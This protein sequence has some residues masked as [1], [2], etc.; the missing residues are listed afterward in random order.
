MSMNKN[1]EYAKQDWM[2]MI[3]KSGA[4]GELTLEE[5]KDFGNLIAY[6]AHPSGTYAQ[7]WNSLNW[8]WLGF[9]EGRKARK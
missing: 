2:E 3:K 9:I 5:Q 4:W 6:V 1:K 7:R 8:I